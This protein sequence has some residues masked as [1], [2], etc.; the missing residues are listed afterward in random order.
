MDVKNYLR[1]INY[2]FNIGAF[3]VQILAKFIKNSKIVLTIFQLVIHK[4][5]FYHS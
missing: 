1:Y 4:S 3:N 5:P 2:F